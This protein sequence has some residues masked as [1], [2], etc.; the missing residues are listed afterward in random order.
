MSSITSMLITKNQSPQ[1]PNNMSPVLNADVTPSP[2]ASMVSVGLI[3]CR[4]P[5]SKLR[6]GHSALLCFKE[7]CESLTTSQLTQRDRGQEHGKACLVWGSA[8]NPNS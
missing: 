6:L 8:W 4:K 7:G 2:L 1:R 3:A 5:F